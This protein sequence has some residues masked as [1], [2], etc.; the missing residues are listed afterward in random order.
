MGYLDSVHLRVLPILVLLTV[1]VLTCAPI[2]AA[3]P[4]G[5]NLN[6]TVGSEPPSVEESCSALGIMQHTLQCQLPSVQAD[7]IILVEVSDVPQPSVADTMGDHFALLGEPASLPG[8]SYDLEIF[9][10]TTS[11]SGGDSI[12]IT[13][14][15]NFPALIVHE[16]TR[17]MGE[18]IHDGS[19]NSTT[20][21]VTVSPFFVPPGSLVIATLLLPS[22]Q[23]KLTTSASA[24]QGY[25]LLAASGGIVDEEAVAPASPSTAQFSL[26][27]PLSWAEVAVTFAPA[28]SASPIPQFGA[29]AILV[30]AIGLV[31]VA[32]MKRGKILK[33]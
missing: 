7:Q 29:P 9:L 22:N 2:V 19:G 33:L 18:D 30:A 28:T 16:I 31:V 17:D 4:I 26:G 8:S 27:S 3:H 15:G 20:P 23:G 11:H 24:G 6:L 10:A 1:A 32:V 25:S 13:G 14:V 21:D 12:N 5:P